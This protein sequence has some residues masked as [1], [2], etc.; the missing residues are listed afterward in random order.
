MYMYM[1]MYMGKKCTKQHYKRFLF[2]FFSDRKRKQCGDF[3]MF[4]GPRHILLPVHQQ[5]SVRTADS[6]GTAAMC[7]LKMA[8]PW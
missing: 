5:R 1:C 8:L 3:K 7:V 4:V 2:F 6:G